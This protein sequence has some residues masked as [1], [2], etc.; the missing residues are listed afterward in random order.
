MRFFR[1]QLHFCAAL[2]LV[3]AAA[4]TGCGGPDQHI[5]LKLEAKNG[6]VDFLIPRSYLSERDA[7]LGI[8]PSKFLIPLKIPYQDILLPKTFLERK[9]QMVTL[10]LHGNRKLPYEPTRIILDSFYESATSDVEGLEKYN[11]RV[12]KSSNIYLGEF[13][14]AR[15][16]SVKCGKRCTMQASFQDNFIYNVSI[17]REALAALGDVDRAMY[18]L[19]ERLTEK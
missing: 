3:T 12:R 19:I 2:I 4:C 8:T 5:A 17:N 10:T 14:D 6:E 9:S 11:Q 15:K 13:D 7:K 16:F 18:E 1:N